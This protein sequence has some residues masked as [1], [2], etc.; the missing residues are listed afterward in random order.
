MPQNTRIFVAV[1]ISSK[2]HTRLCKLSLLTTKHTHY[3]MWLPSDMTTG[4]VEIK[5]SEKNIRW[6]E[7]SVPRSDDRR[8]Q[9]QQ[10]DRQQLTDI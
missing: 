7:M 10:V 1:I 5:S 9:Q 8:L 4:R 3:D 2:I 6:K